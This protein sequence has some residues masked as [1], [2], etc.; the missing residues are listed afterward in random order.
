VRAP[1]SKT[2][3]G[4]HSYARRV[5]APAARGEL[6]LGLPAR[7]VVLTRRH[8]LDAAIALL[9]SRGVAVREASDVAE[10][11][12]LA[13]E[14][15]VE[16]LLVEV[17]A[18]GWNADLGPSTASAAPSA[19][20]PRHVAVRERGRIRL[21]DTADIDW[22]DAARNGTRIHARGAVLRHRRPIGAL[23]R[24][25]A[26]DRFVRIHRSTLVNLDAVV[27]IQLD[28]RGNY[29]ALLRGGRR[30]AIGRTFRRHVRSLWR[31]PEPPHGQG[32]DCR[33]SAQRSTS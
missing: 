1:A 18:P 23:A 4:W 26:A 17:G 10:A 33:C 31:A 28:A 29:V 24:E 12:R 22:V 21:L 11:L 3:H 19:G 27:E 5:E 15:N 2:A 8:R 13:H 14:A 9:R 30:L 6:D 25:L 20:A 7:V 32:S 16:A